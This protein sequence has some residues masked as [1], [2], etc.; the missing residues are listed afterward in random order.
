MRELS[1][2]QLY[3]MGEPLGS[4]VTR[5]KPGGG[6]ECGGGGGSSSSSSATTT[7]T[8][9]KRLS[10]QSGVGVSSDSST[11][12][13]N[14]LD[15][16]AI[17]SALDTVKANDATQGQGFQALLGLADTLFQGA[18]TILNKAQDTT[19]AQQAAIS[20]AQTNASG[21]IDQKTMIVLAASAA[22]VLILRK[23]G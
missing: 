22:A 20:T 1:R 6:Y 21:Q 2:N 10:I 14:A 16:G 19:L 4:S 23:K 5:A 3:A 15:A 17:Q 9:D 8:T 11:V 12:T 13:V 18:G 7:N